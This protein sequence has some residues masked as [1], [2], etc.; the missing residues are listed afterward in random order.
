MNRTGKNLTPPD[1]GKDIRNT[2]YKL[3]DAALKTVLQLYEVQHVIGIGR[4]AE[5][6]AKKVIEENKMGNIK[7]HFMV[8][9]SP[10]SAMANKG[11][12]QLAYNALKA[13]QLFNTVFDQ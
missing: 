4:F 7:V 5:M 6:R 1:L 11:W 10:A 3:C 13:S 9:P 2:L 12:D 8:H